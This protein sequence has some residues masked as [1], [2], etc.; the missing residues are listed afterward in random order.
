MKSFE[1]HRVKDAAARRAAF[2]AREPKIWWE[3]H[4]YPTLVIIDP[5]VA[6]EALRRPDLVIPD[7]RRVVREIRT[8]HDVPLPA[9]LHAMDFLPLFL[10]GEAHTRIR[11][12]LGPFLS[13]RLREVEP[14]LPALIH[15][16]LAGLPVD[17]KVEFVSQLLLPL[18]RDVFSSL[19][20]RDLTEEITGFSL[21]R[22][23][24]AAHGVTSLSRLDGMID[25]VF[26]FLDSDGCEDDDFICRLCCLVF[27]FDNVLS[28]LAENLAASFQSSNGTTPAQLPAF[29][30]EVMLSASYRHALEETALAGH[31]LKP[32]TLVRIHLEPFGYSGDKT[33]NAALFGVGR[34]ACIGKQLTLSV[35]KHLSEAF[36]ALKIRGAISA[37][38]CECSHSFNFV[39]TLEVDIR[40]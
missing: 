5:V 10:E 27:G 3:Q 37:Y 8:R 21:I 15:G 22:I 9:L 2:S 24:E 18:S 13:A 32:N 39:K 20:G 6:A 38:D 35:W 40:P 25:R 23:F 36:N 33:L 19:V 16:L 11:K 26:S 7:L 30:T 34:H 12:L 14:E 17:G 29:P 28:T 4:V 31:K 1:F